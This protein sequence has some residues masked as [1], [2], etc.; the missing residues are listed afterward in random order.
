MHDTVEINID[1]IPSPVF[2]DILHF[3]SLLPPFGEEE[4][5]TPSNRFKKQKRNR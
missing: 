1:M 5:P 4:K 2:Y 3:S